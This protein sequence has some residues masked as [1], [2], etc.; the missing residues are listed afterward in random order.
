MLY[1]ISGWLCLAWC[2]ANEIVVVQI[3]HLLHLLT[4][5]VSS[6]SPIAFIYVIPPGRGC[7]SSCASR[8]RPTME[9]FR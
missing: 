6:Y 5:S 1:C 9:N 4:A 7:F 3:S 2:G 8:P